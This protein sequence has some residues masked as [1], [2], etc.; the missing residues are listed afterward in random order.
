MNF[1]NCVFLLFGSSVRIIRR[2]VLHIERALPVTG[3]HVARAFKLLESLN[4]KGKL[5]VIPTENSLPKFAP[6]GADGN[7]GTNTSCFL[8]V[9]I[10]STRVMSPLPQPLRQQRGSEIIHFCSAAILVPVSGVKGTFDSGPFQ[11]Q[12]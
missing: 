12:I 3:L 1:P 8:A 6:R 10:L 4:V 2:H 5:C 11:S 9:G 7:F